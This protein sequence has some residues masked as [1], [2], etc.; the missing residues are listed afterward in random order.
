MTVGTPGFEKLLRASEPVSRQSHKLCKWRSTRQPATSFQES[1]PN[2]EPT[3]TWD[4]R[5]DP[6]IKFADTDV[7][8]MFG[9]KP[10]YPGSTPGCPA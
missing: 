6:W 10:I 3:P 5:L 7:R 9:V 4:G 2:W 8:Y 1:N